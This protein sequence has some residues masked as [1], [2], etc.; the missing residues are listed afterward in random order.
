MQP[1]SV[2]VRVSG[3]D[4][5]DYDLESLRD[6][7]SIVLQKNVLFSGTVSDNLRWGKEDANLKEME[8]SCMLAQALDFITK[9][10]DKYES[11]VERGGS[12]FQVDK[13]KDFL[14]QEL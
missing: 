13:N 3:I 2:I 1:T 8:E 11:H 6:A 9:L 12:N 5:R 14:L 7:V 10:G 4:V